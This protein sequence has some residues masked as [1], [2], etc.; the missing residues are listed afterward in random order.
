MW[1][2]D[3]TLRREMPKRKKCGRE[4]GEC[5]Y[6]ECNIN[7]CGRRHFLGSELRYRHDEMLNRACVGTDGLK[8][9]RGAGQSLAPDFEGCEMSVVW[10]GSG[11]NNKGSTL[12]ERSGYERDVV[13]F[14]EWHRR[15]WNTCKGV[16]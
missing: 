10:G 7:L 4:G 11:F 6:Y 13:D 14:G 5:S 16:G 12:R 2:R 9:E 3:A 8:R 15:V 1:G